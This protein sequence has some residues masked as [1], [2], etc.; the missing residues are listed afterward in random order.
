[1]KTVNRK[2]SFE[3]KNCGN[4]ADALLNTDRAEKSFCKE[5]YG[6]R[7]DTRVNRLNDL[8]GREWATLSKSIERYNGTRSEKQK[9]HGAAFPLSLVEDHIK[10]YTKAGETVLDPFV[11]VGTTSQAAESLGRK[12]IG[13]E[14]NSD[15]VKLAR[16][17]IKDKQNHKI[18]H[19]DARTMS[20][21]LEN[22]SIDFLI[23]S[24]PYANL[25]TKIK[26]DFGFKWREHSEINMSSNPKPYSPS[27]ND[28]GNLEYSAFLN[29]ITKIF[30]ASFNALKNDS[31][32]VW[33][34]KD[35]RDLA[36]GLPYVNFHADIISCAIKSQFTLWDIRIYD[37]TVFRPLVVLGYPSRNYYLNIG[38]SYIL[39]FKKIIKVS[40]RGSKSKS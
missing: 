29:E 27:K 22:D 20:K 15:F 4:E 21:H 36:N 12:S 19:D 5:C 8:S 18:I 32:A 37:Q 38:H 24:P 31:Y 2:I 7:K 35:Y 14:L 9:V 33:V 39:I 28:L 1:M 34:V 11:G 16:Q 3:C 17:D 30:E 6:K 26:G 13:I 25:L 40:K 23:T 10:I